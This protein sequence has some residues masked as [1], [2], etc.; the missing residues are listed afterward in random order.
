MRNRRAFSLI[1]LLVVVG[2]IAILIGILLPTMARV[3][4]HANRIKCQSNLR[5][6]GQLLLIYSNSNQGWIYPVGPGDPHD[7]AAADNFCRMGDML[8]PEE[9]WPVHVKG[10]ERY[11][12]PLLFCPTDQQPVA[13]HSYP[14][15]WY[16]AQHHV[17][18][19]SGSG[20]LGGLAPGEVVLMGEKR[21][22]TDWYYIGARNEY[23]D[24]ADPW[25]HDIRLGSN[26]LFLDLHVA[27]MEPRRAE[28]GYDPWEVTQ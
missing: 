7:S 1:E 23:Q 25:K 5:T 8:P 19:S 28:R 11:N 20:R 2:I 13:E 27:P 21:A 15:N 17:L 12:H 22:D 4:Q 6:I 10:L 14:L 9:R 26:Y 16:L 18:F 24:A 3:R